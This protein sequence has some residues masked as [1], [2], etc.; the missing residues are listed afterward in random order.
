MSGLKTWSG[1]GVLGSLAFLVLSN[2]LTTTAPSAR[3]VVGKHL[4]L[5]PEKPYAPTPEDLILAAGFSRIADYASFTLYEG[6]SAATS[7][8][9]ENLKNED[10]E[11]RVAEE[12]DSIHL[13]QHNVDAD[14]GIASPPYDNA[15]FTKSGPSGLYLLALRGYP[16]Q[17]WIDALEAAGVKIIEPLPPS[18]YLVQGDRT[19]LEGLRTTQKFVRGVFPMLPA[20]KTE[21]LKKIPAG[22]D[23]YRQ[24]VVEAFEATPRD[25]PKPFLESVMPPESLSEFRETAS[26]VRYGGAAS[27]LD[28]ATLSNFE[29]VYSIGPVGDAAPSSE[30]QASLLIQPIPTPILTST[31]GFSPTPKPI[32]VPLTVTPYGPWL[33]GKGIGDFANSKVALL[34]TG[35]DAG[36]PIKVTPPPPTPTP[37]LHPDFSLLGSSTVIT[38]YQP[39]GA[40][41]TP[42]NQTT[43]PNSD[44]LSKGT[45]GTVSTSV[46]TAWQ[47]VSD[48]TPRSDSQGYHYAYGTAP[49]VSTAV[50]KFFGNATNSS[51]HNVWTRLQNALGALSAWAPNIVN[52]S[53]NDAPPNCS[54][55]QISQILDI[56]TRTNSILH[57]VAAGNVPDDGCAYVGA[58]ATSKNAIAVGATENYTLGPSAGP[59]WVNT[60]GTGYVSTCP[61][62]YWPSSGGVSKESARNIT[63]F[64]ASQAPATLYKPDLVA[65]GLRVTGPVTR[66]NTF[67]LPPLSGNGVFCDPNI[68][69]IGGISYRFSAGTSFAAPVVSGAAAVVRKWYANI[70]SNPSANPSPAQ[71]KAILINGA[72]DIFG[73]VV[74]QVAADNTNPS[75]TAFGHIPDPYQGL[76]LVSLDRLLDSGANHYWIDQSVTLNT[77]AP[78]WSSN[79]N[80]V[81][82]NKD[83]RVT[84]VY[85]DRALDP[86][87]GSTDSLVNTLD[88]VVCRSDAFQCWHGDEWK[89]DGTTLATSPT[90]NFTDG[91]N[92][93]KEVIIPAKSFTLPFQL[94]VQV[95]ATNLTG[96]GV[97]P[98]GTMLQQDFAIFASNIH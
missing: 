29:S 8:L 14:T 81:D 44:G 22:E 11:G 26:R 69:T 48:P 41:I 37:G 23:F 46:I 32:T 54:Y 20:M 7:A 9:I 40:T 91:L 83:T 35:F 12:L 85:T 30:R 73:G 1:L 96:D 17:E 92:N 4:T 97:N 90:H 62:N 88:L 53:W 60:S 63:S 21:S 5:V 38:E 56:S 68:G 58:P 24:V 15:A 71:T 66:D 10:Y 67:T 79:V 2:T 47:S 52:H 31:P 45:H 25:S 50:D 43:D 33:A 82:R 18:S 61:Y 3:L 28:I 59:G 65:P 64:S 95:T 86:F 80:V 55:L 74:R 19:V 13:F 78:I 27:D 93:V 49:T 76:G 36:Y 51:N 77:V 75:G 89:T 84:L 94:L 42:F 16:L 39:P 57:V 70:T 98:V 6:P 72:R 87:G 34:D